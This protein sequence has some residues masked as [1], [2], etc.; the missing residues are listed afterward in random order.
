MNITNEVVTRYIDGL[1]RPLTSELAELRRQAEADHIP[2]ILRDTERFL[3]SMLTLI[4]PRRI[5]EIGAA[6]GYSSS[7][8]AQVCGAGTKIT[9][10][11]ADPVMFEKASDNIRRLGYGE[12]IEV[13]FGDARGTLNQLEPGY[14]FVFIDAAKSHYR[15]FYDGALRL[16]RKGGAIVCDNILMRAMTASDEYYPK[17]KH[18]TSIRKMREFLD[19]ITASD[20]AVTSVFAA[21]DGIALSI[22]ASDQTEID[23]GSRG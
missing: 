8:F 10:L 16:C 22:V 4:R 20:A 18:R 13:L 9:T 7:C 6:V 23:A 2:V 1:Y 21:G 3:V 11:E 14:D 17:G 5:L 12:Q 19:Y 15:A